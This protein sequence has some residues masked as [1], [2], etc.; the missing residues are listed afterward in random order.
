[1]KTNSRHIW[2]RLGIVLTLLTITGWSIPVYADP[3]QD[4]IA[5]QIMD[6]QKNNQRWIEIDLNRQRLIAWEGSKM[7]YAVIISS[8]KPATPTNKGSFQIQTKFVSTRMTGDDY[9][10]PDVPYTMYYDGGMAIH[11]AYWHNL[12]GNPVTHGCT[13]VAVNHAKWLF[14]WAEVGTP[15]IV[16]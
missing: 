14:E 2:Q 9:D 15:V 5:Y 4:Q 16:H 11:G 8:G 13:N 1:M 10:V 6:F 3:Q 12:F 7:V